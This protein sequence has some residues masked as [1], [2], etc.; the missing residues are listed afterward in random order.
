MAK[1]KNKIEKN[2]KLNNEIIIYE[3][4]G[5]KLMLEVRMEND[6]IWLPQAKIA[7]LFG[8]Q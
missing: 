8:V 6:T 5:G 1:S 4:S 7:Q 3:G 2:N